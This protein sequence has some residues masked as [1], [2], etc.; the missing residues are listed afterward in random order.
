[1]TLSRRAFSLNWSVVTG[2]AFVLKPA[3][4]ITLDPVVETTHP[5]VRGLAQDGVYAFK[6]IAYGGLTGGRN[7]F[8]PPRPPNAWNGVRNCLQ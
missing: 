4:A 1:M 2:A 7:R 8:M 3:F 5:R 6:G